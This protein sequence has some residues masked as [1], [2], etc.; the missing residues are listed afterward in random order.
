MNDSFLCLPSELLGVIF[1]FLNP[2]SI[3]HFAST[4]QHFRDISSTT[5]FQA[6]FLLNYY[7]KGSAIYSLYSDHKSFMTTSLLI[8][9]MANGAIFPRFLS[10]MIVQDV[11][12]LV[13]F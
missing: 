10:Q 9:M 3:T 6:A 13:L 2:S 4:N 1:S 7:G 8:S 12:S 5:T 11:N